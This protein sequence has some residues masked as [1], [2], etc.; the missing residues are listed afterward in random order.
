MPLNPP[1]LVVALVSMCPYSMIG[2]SAATRVVYASSN[3]AVAV[4][5]GT[6]FAVR[7]RRAADPIVA[8]IKVSL[9]EWSKRRAGIVHVEGDGALGGVEQRLGADAETTPLRRIEDDSG[10]RGA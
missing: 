8:T 10:H 3:P 7:E 1:G 2:T 4:A 6:A 5:T 9:E